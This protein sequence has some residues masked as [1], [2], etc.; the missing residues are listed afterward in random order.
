MSRQDRSS[1][2]GRPEAVSI[3][4]IGFVLLLVCWQIVRLVV[5]GEASHKDFVVAATTFVAAI[6][7]AALVL[8]IVVLQW[9]RRRSIRWATLS[10]RYPG[11][12]IFDAFPTVS[13]IPPARPDTRETLLRRAS[14]TS[15]TVVVTPDAMRVFR[16]KAA[17]IEMDTFSL[18]QVEK[19]RLGAIVA[20][21][22]AMPAVLFGVVLLNHTFQ[23]AAVVR[24]K[25]MG[26][27][28]PARNSYGQGIIGDIQRLMQTPLG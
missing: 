9:S 22:R 14:S 21:S 10:T 27:T 11:A 7:V 15:L 3:V 24:S 4:F 6:L 26:G 16:G 18:A 23:A 28:L 25:Y 2:G 20:G 5:L 1:S 12:I 17:P 19:V 13:Y 8:I